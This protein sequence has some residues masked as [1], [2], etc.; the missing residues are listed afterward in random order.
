MTRYEILTRARNYIARKENWTKGELQND[1]QQCCALGAVAKVQ[2]I[3]TNEDGGYDPYG[4]LDKQP[5]VKVLAKAALKTKVSRYLTDNDEPTNIVI[6]IN[7]TRG[8]KAVLKMFDKAIE[9][10]KPKGKEKD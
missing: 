5:A 3:S 7:D 9:M 8:H 6:S 2:G 1:N 4:I 10:V